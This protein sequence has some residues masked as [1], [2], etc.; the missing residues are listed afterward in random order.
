[1]KGGIGIIVIRVHKRYTVLLATD[2]PGA[3]A[4]AG[5]PAVDVT[6]APVF[7]AGAPVLTAG[8]PVFIPAP[9]AGGLAMPASA[10]FVLRAVAAGPPAPPAPTPYPA[11]VSLYFHDCRPNVA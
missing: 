11:P 9:V 8:A 2:A 3:V 4:V 7:T 10:A 1:M 6:G 5:C